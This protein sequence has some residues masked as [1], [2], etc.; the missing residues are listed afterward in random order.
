[1]NSTIFIRVEV[2]RKTGATDLSCQASEMRGRKW[3]RNRTVKVVQTLHPAQAGYVRRF[4]H[5][6]CTDR[7]TQL[8]LLQ[9]S[10]SPYS[11]A[12]STSFL[13]VHALYT[14]QLRIFSC[15]KTNIGQ[16]KVLDVGRQPRPLQT[17]AY[18]TQTS[19]HW[20]LFHYRRGV[21]VGTPHYLVVYPRFETP[22]GEEIFWSLFPSLKIVEWLKLW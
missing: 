9:L 12:S 17:T 8:F 10:F 2:T 6:E 18:Q 5:C 13:L 3:K 21:V 15:K 4:W 7:V 1:V 20:L 19:L 11:D 16:K 22:S 14:I